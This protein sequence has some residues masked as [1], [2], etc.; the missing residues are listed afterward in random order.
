MLQIVKTF[1][2]P[3]PFHLAKIYYLVL[4]Y[5]LLQCFSIANNHN[6]VLKRMRCTDGLFSLSIIFG[7]QYEGTPREIDHTSTCFIFFGRRYGIG[8]VFIVLVDVY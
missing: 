6:T 2:L 5:F 3:L 7:I 1:F 4:F 8:E